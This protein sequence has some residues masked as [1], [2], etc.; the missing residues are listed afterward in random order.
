MIHSMSERTPTHAL[1]PRQ[2]DLLED[3]YAVAAQVHSMK[4]RGMTHAQIVDSLADERVRG[5]FPTARDVDIHRLALNEKHRITKGAVSQLATAYRAIVDLGVVPDRDA[6][7]AVYRVVARGGTASRR[8]SILEALDTLPAR[9]RKSELIIQM[10]SLYL[11][12]RSKGAPEILRQIDGWETANLDHSD[13]DLILSR[14][15]ARLDVAE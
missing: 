11:E 8:R 12:F 6:F 13:K 4:L 9:E 7:G 2:V 14:A 1:K 5:L 15:R 10:Q 3:R